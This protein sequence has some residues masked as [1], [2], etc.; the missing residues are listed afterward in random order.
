VTHDQTEAMTLGDRVVVLDRGRIQQVDTPVGL[1]ERPA[2]TFVAGFVGTP[3][4]NL[5]DAEYGDG[6]LAIEGQRCSVPPALRAALS[7]TSGPVVVGIRP[8]AFVPAEQVRDGALGAVPDPFAREMLGSETLLRARVGAREVV[9]RLPGV[10]RD[11]PPRV[12]APPDAL[13]VFAS[14]GS[15]LGP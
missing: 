10:V 8:E 14:D 4:M 13:H 9:V 7:R 5:L 15:R 6:V 1:Y 11:V 3:A 12:A 2:T